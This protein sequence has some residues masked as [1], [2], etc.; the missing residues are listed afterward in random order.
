M[1]KSTNAEPTDN[2][3]HDFGWWSAWT[4]SSRGP[5][6][7]G[8]PPFAKWLQCLEAFAPGQLCIHR[9]QV[10]GI[11]AWFGA[12]GLS[13]SGVLP[14]VSSS[15]ALPELFLRGQPV[16]LV[17]LGHQRFTTSMLG[18]AL[19]SAHCLLL[20]L[21]HLSFHSGEDSV[22]CWLSIAHNRGSPALARTGLSYLSFLQDVFKLKQKGGCLFVFL[23]LLLL[24]GI[25][26][27][28][29]KGS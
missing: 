4:K 12:A 14:R 18:C 3:F 20:R 27:S 9:I 13:S 19:T 21:T 8:F 23:L 5:W 6:I 16:P 17:T 24:G 2:I 26:C 29:C 10:P 7:S 1:V 15:D 25:H 11:P 28:I 22:L